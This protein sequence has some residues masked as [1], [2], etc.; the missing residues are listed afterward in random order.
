MDA[1]SDPTGRQMAEHGIHTLDTGFQR[2]CFDAAYLIVEQGRGA[3]IDCGTALA[4]PSLLAALPAAGLRAE[5]VDWLILTHVHL[6]HAGGAGALLRHLPNAK[7][8]VH[9][10][11][12]PHMID[13]TRLLAGATEVYGEAEIA[14]SYGE[15]VAVPEARV[16]IAEDGG[17]VSLAGRALLTIDTPGHARHHLCV[18]DARSR[19]WFTGDT[20]GLSYRELD[21][22]QGPFILPTSSPVQFEPEAMRASIARMLA[23]DPAAMYLTHYGRVA[24]PAAL[25]RALIEQIDA[26]A[27]L[28]RSCDDRPDRH[29][30]LVAAL[31]ELYLER[32]HAHAVPLDD[33]A[34]TRVLAMDIELNAQGLA[35]WLD[36][37]RRAG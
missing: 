21:S 18:W 33:A 23:H 6:D 20:F 2:P 37:A 14:R 24:P 36:R 16:V 17:S 34:V 8:L 7:L 19:A 26:M 4:V 32:A 22:A 5:D 13:P 31:T 1:S 35:S 10:R 9:P 29:R 12:A 27:A 28:A 25:G 11:G 3:F 30:C 15:V